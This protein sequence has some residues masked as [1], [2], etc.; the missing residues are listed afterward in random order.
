MSARSALRTLPLRRIGIVALLVA[1]ALLI[2]SAIA[3]NIG[4]SGLRTSRSTVDRTNVILRGMAELRTT[5]RTAETGQRGFLLT[6][7]ER[8]LAPYDRA[9]RQVLAEL[10]TLRRLVRDR[11][12]QALLKRMEPVL[13]A[14][15]EEL[16]R[17]VALRRTS[18][19]AALRIVRTD[20][21]QRLTEE[22]EALATRFVDAEQALLAARVAEEERSARLTA[23]AAA[24]TGLL[25]LMSA[26]LGA[27]L[28]LQQRS[29]DA[30]LRYSHE[31]E[32]QVEE[33]TAKL[34]DANKELDAFAYTI[35]HDL[36]APLRAMHGYAD[37][38]VEDHGDALGEEGRHFA[39]AI[40][41]AA[42][43]MNA[44]IEDILTY[45]R[46]A[47]EELSLRTVSLDTVVERARADLLERTSTPAGVSVD[48][49]L[50]SVVA[51]PAVMMQVI[52]NLLANAVKFV[53][54]GV[55]ARVH[56]RSEPAGA[57]LRLWVEDDGIGIAPDHLA[58]IFEPFERL[59]GVESYPGTG[60][61]LAIVRR[62]VDRMGG[63]CGVESEL[64]SGSRFWI[65]LPRAVE[66]GAR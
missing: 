41:A 36:R 43:R 49:P 26:L 1:A 4:L 9:I 29:A 62:A 27:Y 32:H 51:H 35:S 3:V 48:V 24:V 13:D 18:L 5:V 28:L 64:G 7:Q 17:T 46:M 30:L 55:E 65:E 53:A 11:G 44:L 47:R 61:G 34:R 15:L 2:L 16:A 25:S 45:A 37:A 66:E 50:G 52:D 39:G 21:G 60:I 14:K 6:G 40:S 59:H 54:V 31:L 23:T 20:V 57:L 56:V 63:T 12:Q 10:V 58:R 33:R 22:F 38:L 19:D 8:Y 42:L